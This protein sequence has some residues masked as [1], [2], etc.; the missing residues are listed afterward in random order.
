MVKSVIFTGNKGPRESQSLETR[1]KNLPGDQDL[2]AFEN[3]P[4][5]DGNP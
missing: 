4:W 1:P 3:L 5:E 2:T